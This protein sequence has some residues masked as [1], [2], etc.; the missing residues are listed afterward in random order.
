MAYFDWKAEYSVNVA[1]IDGQHKRLVDLL[2]QLYDAMKAGKGNEVVGKVLEDLVDYTKKHLADEERLLQSNGY[3]AFAGHKAEHVRITAQVVD[4]H[5]QYKEGNVGISVKL[6]N[7]IKDWLINH[8]QTVDKKY[9][10]F[11]NGKGIV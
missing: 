6:G 9:S 2:N 5:R 8:I 3:P 1:M 11:L 7:F 10:A 4:Y